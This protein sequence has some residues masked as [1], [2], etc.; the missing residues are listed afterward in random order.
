MNDRPSF[1]RL[2]LL[3]VAACAAALV[4]VPLVTRAA[5][6]S[7]EEV[8]K[9]KEALP[10]KATAKPAKPRKLLIFCRCEGFRHSSIPYAAK[11]IEL[12]GEK[13]GAYQSVTSDDMAMFD[14]GTLGQFDAVVFNNTVSLKFEKPE[15]RQALIDYMHAGGGMVGIHGGADNF[16]NW[17]EGAEMMGAVFSGHPW[18]VCPVKLDDPT[19]PLVRVFDGKG[20]WIRDEIYKF[21]DPYS[22]EKLRVLLSMEPN[23]GDPGN[24][25]R[26]DRDNPVAW[27]QQVGGGRSFY[28]SL[29]HRHDV[30][31]NPV[32]LQ[33]YLDGIQYALGDLKADATP[34]A[35]LDP[36]PKP[37]LPPEKEK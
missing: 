17:P 31:W 37:A 4:M 27:I 13:T 34:S 19:H 15:H 11:A 36:Q 5:G 35:K 24:K 2:R 8:Q 29:G 6:P 10:E 30:F 9:I 25:G 26:E 28:C 32:L 23:L 7:D 22:R 1:R 16:K 18:G 20:F 21:R 3:A 12:M 14:A 33:F